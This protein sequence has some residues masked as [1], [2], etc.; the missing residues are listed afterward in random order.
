MNTELDPAGQAAF[1]EALAEKS[2]S[3]GLRGD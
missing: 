3:G 2:D 1:L